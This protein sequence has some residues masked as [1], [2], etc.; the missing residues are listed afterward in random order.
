[1]TRS[2]RFRREQTRRKNKEK[3]IG[4]VK[5]S[6]IKSSRKHMSSLSTGV[7]KDVRRKKDKSIS[8]IPEAPLSL[9]ASPLMAA[10]NF[11]YHH[12]RNRAEEAEENAHRAIMIA[13]R[14]RD[15]A[16]DAERISRR[17]PTAPAFANHARTRAEHAEEYAHRT[18]MIAERE[19]AA[20]DV[21]ERI[22]SSTD[23]PSNLFGHGINPAFIDRLEP[24]SQHRYNT[25]FP[26]SANALYAPHSSSLPPPPGRWLR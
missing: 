6:S 13:E 10:A 9:S 1:M 15:A 23:A 14:E 2:K 19:R 25:Y 5:K 26:K 8:I 3:M 21:A 22:S 17:W 7:F 12:A 4:G 20:A 16:N 24:R 18:I 11:A